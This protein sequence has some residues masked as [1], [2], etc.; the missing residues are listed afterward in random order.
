M[1][2]KIIGIAAGVGF[3]LSIL[4]GLIAQ[5]SII[6]IFLRGFICA[7]VCAGMS[8][9]IMFIF[10]KYLAEGSELDSNFASPKTTGNVIDITLDDEKLAEEKDAPKFKVS[11][12]LKN[13]LDEK[14][15]TKSEAKA[16]SSENLATA[17]EEKQ[18]TSENNTGSSENVETN[19][20]KPMNVASVT[21]SSEQVSEKKNK[22]GDEELDALPDIGDIEKN[23][24]NDDT[25]VDSFSSSGDVGDVSQSVAPSMPSSKSASFS[26]GSNPSVKDAATIAQAI[27]SVLAREGS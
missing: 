10:G 26:D 2:P 7:A 19:S 21:Q 15:E 23:S 16:A 8:A 12:N 3:V 27:R 25:V 20:F 24:N 17:A 1:N 5:N 11:E 13:M 4:I 9:G 14:S 22:V 6:A 18:A